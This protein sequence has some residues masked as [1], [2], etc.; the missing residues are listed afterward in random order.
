[1]DSIDPQNDNPLD[2]YSNLDHDKEEI[3]DLDEEN[4]SNN[5]NY[6]NETEKNEQI[7]AIEQTSGI[8]KSNEDQENVDKNR[9]K[10]DELASPPK[11]GKNDN[12]IRFDS[13]GE[14]FEM[15]ENL[16]KPTIINDNNEINQKEEEVIKNGE[17]SLADPSEKETNTK[18][19][20]NQTIK[21]DNEKE[22]QP[23]EDSSHENKEEILKKTP[24]KED[25]KK[26]EDEE[27]AELSEIPR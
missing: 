9:E 11:A 6:V 17:G 23:N 1:M 13:P 15:N 3:I 7:E 2:Y 19:E 26:E 21:Q 25:E 10:I 12:I 20:D 14:D 18:T 8:E 24:E 5:D 22:I 4:E 16:S 27:P